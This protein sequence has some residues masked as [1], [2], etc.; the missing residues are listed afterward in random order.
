[1]KI[2]PVL[3]DHIQ[4]KHTSFDVDFQLEVAT[5]GGGVEF[6]GVGTRLLAGEQERCFV[7]VA[8]AVE[9][10]SQHL[11]CLLAALV[12]GDLCFVGVEPIGGDADSACNVFL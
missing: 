2:K 10:T 3:Y 8:E 5:G 9:R 7:A 6:D 11:G 12:D 4:T 1:M